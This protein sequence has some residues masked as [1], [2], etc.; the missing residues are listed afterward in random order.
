M[1]HRRVRKFLVPIGISVLLLGISVAVPGNA[2]AITSAQCANRANNTAPKLLECIQ[3]NDLLDLHE[4][5]PE[6]RQRPPRPGRTPV[7]QLRRARLPGVG[8]VRREPDVAVGIPGQHP[9]LQVLLLRVH[10]HAGVP[11]G[12]AR[13]ARLHDHQRLEPGPEHRHDHRSAA[14]RR[15]H[16]H[17]AD[18]RAELDQRLHRSPTSPASSRAAS[19]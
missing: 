11:R 14:A 8:A 5:V 2:G 1:R 17:P 13:R 3:T 9:D 6:H 12:L 16:R 4:G 10:R 19:R 18:A 15:R 7:P